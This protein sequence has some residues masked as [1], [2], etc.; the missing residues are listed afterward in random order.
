MTEIPKKRGRPAKAK[1]P[2]KEW[3]VSVPR[4]WTSAPIF[5]PRQQNGPRTVIVDE[6]QWTIGYPRHPFNPKLEVGSQALDVRHALVAIALLN[7][8]DYLPQ[9][10]S[11]SIEFTIY[12]L[13][14]A[15]FGNDA[16]YNYDL[17][18]DLITD[19]ERIWIEIKPLEITEDNRRKPRYFRVVGIQKVERDL[20][21]SGN[22]KASIQFDK[23]FLD[24]IRD[25]TLNYVRMDV[26]HK[27]YSKKLALA[28]Y[29]YLP[30]R[31]VFHDEKDPFEITLTK[32]LEQNSLNVP[33]AKSERLKFFQRDSYDV[34][35][36]I[37]GQPLAGGG[38][39]RAR[40]VETRSKED[41]K[42]Q[43][44]VEGRVICEGPNK[45]Y[46]EDIWLKTGLPREDFQRKV[47]SPPQ[48]NVYEKQS[49]ESYGLPLD[50]YELF[51][52]RVKAL[53]G[54]SVF[55]EVL[56]DIKSRS[57]GGDIR[58]LHSYMLKVIKSVLAPCN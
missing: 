39:L 7:L 41:W 51:L 56:G 29:L 53:L 37:D 1:D 24:Y 8:K 6:F 2:K 48:L 35:G 42:I 38:G 46:L 10:E 19:L 30:S 49:F 52:R 3:R 55:Q 15:V 34:I 20:L 40:L 11:N 14:K 22:D 9:L 44:W 50:K 36:E 32:F 21:D 27:L 28:M 33:T 31:A 26:L 17:I 43:T 13:A 4:E 47:N 54:D 5:A 18:R 57:L 12:E 23:T 45:T 16:K 25:T 58:N